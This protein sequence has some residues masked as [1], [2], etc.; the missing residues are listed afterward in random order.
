MEPLYRV[1]Q[2]VLVNIGG[3]L[4]NRTPGVVTSVKTRPELVTY[5]VRFSEFA[6]DHRIASFYMAEDL[7]PLDAR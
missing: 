6:G 4:E 3:C 5:E 7:T 2:Q 1:G